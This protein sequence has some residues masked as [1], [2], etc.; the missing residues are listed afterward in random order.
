MTPPR[1]WKEMR[2]D[3]S[4]LAATVKVMALWTVYSLLDKTG[5]TLCCSESTLCR[6]KYNW[7][8]WLGV[9]LD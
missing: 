9:F 4:D 1:D 2:T 5:K 8:T 6:R 7:T 3:G